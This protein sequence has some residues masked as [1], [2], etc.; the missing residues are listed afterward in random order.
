MGGGGVSRGVSLHLEFLGE[1]F[2]GFSLSKPAL[3]QLDGILTSFI[4]S[5]GT[6]NIETGRT[7][8]TV[9][10]TLRINQVMRLDTSGDEANPIWVFQSRTRIIYMH[11]DDSTWHWATNKAEHTSNTFNMRYVVVDCDLNVN[12]YLATKDNLN[13]V[14]QSVSGKSMQ[15]F[16]QMINPNPVN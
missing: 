7:N 8:N 4:S 12:K 16:G 11:V 13:A 6:I 3:L 14:F 15:E 5:L 1:L 10:Q 9:D 2:K